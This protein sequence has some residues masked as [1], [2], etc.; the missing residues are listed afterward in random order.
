MTE[1]KPAATAADMTAANPF[2][3]LRR[4]DITDSHLFFGRDEQTYELLR[5]LRLMHFLAVIG[6]SGC[7]KSSLIRAGVMAALRDGFLAD[8]GD[9]RLVTLQP[10]NGPLQAWIDALRPHVRPGTPDDAIVSNP[11]AAL[12]SARGPIAILVD[13]FEE[14]FQFVAR[15][16]R[17]DEAR[18]FVD[19]IIRAAAPDARLYTIL[20]MRSEYLAQCAEYPLLADGINSGLHLVSRMTPAQVRE[21]IV[22]PV[23]KAGAAI[24]VALAN[25]L[26][27]EAARTPDGLPVL[28]DALMRMWANRAPF[29]PLGDASLG[30]AGS[31]GEL[32]NDHAEQV[33]AALS[34]EQKAA[35]E[36]LFRCITEMTEEG[37][38]VRRATEFDRIAAGTGVPGPTLRSVVDAFEREGFLVVTPSG[39]GRS[40]LIDISHEA[41]ARQWRR[42]GSKDPLATGWIVKESRQR[43]ALLQVERAAKEWADN[44]QATDF[45]FKG[46]RLENAV[47]HIDGREAHLSETGR[48]FL[49]TSQTRDARRRWMTP[50][51]LV[52]AITAVVLI[53]GLALFSANQRIERQADAIRAATAE[54]QR[55]V[56]ASRAAAAET[57]L[58][59]EQLERSPDPLPPPPP[60]QPSPTKKPPVT[61][62]PNPTGVQTVAPPVNPDPA[63]QAQLPPR[64]YIQIRDE[65]Q[66]A[67]A[68]TA[69]EA[70]RKEK[71]VVPGIE[72]VTVGPPVTELRYLQDDE[73]DDARRAVAV[74]ANVDVQA[75]LR[76]VRL[77]GRSRDRHYELWLAPPASAR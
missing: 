11:A 1:A 74:L 64:V 4:F 27:D 5:R 56:E 14:L 70:L 42:L 61:T 9:W 16:G 60:P 15:T 29:E 49:T 55:Q 17:A 31:L 37:N 52:P 32:L 76:L 21:A 65:S 62:L 47:R 67:Q 40:P 48:R 34:P 2:V 18:A 41:I 44:A 23:H 77:K 54:A 66:R 46:L 72:V 20:T 50:K 22:T 58:R 25:R 53:V 3:G 8:D 33:Y 28:Q 73:E 35:T 57:V 45:L 24:T 75:T 6:P 71:F 68:V 39:E 43:A 51:V 36:K 26:A 69:A 63:P 30:T 13:Q 38:V 10:G 12:D 19:S 7:G 59:I